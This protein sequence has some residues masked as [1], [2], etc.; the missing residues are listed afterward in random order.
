[1][2][3]DFLAAWVEV[4]AVE[5]ILVT[6]KFGGV[7]EDLKIPAAT[8]VGDLIEVFNELFRING[9]ILHAEPKGIIL[10]CGKTLKEQG[11]GHGARLMLG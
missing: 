11:I 3:E 5:F 9:A 6:L 4:H 2:G 10:D 7:E 8:P 1:M